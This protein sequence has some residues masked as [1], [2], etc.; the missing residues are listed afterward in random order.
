MDG[1]GQGLKFW[2]SMIPFLND[3]GEDMNLSSAE[4]APPIEQPS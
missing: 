2:E 3:I 1:W 4:V